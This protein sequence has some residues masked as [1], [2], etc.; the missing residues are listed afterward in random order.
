MMKLGPWL[1]GAAIG[2]VIGAVLVALKMGAF[3]PYSQDQPWALPTFNYQEIGRDSIFITGSLKGERVGYPYNTW[4]IRCFRSEE[5]CEVSNVSEIGKN[6]LGEID[7]VDWPIISWTDSVV[8]LQDDNSANDTACARATITI[9]R[10]GKSV[11]Y[12]SAS[13]NADKDYCKKFGH[14]GTY[15]WTI[16]QPKQP[17]EAGATR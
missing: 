7:T 2:G 16:G 8:V 10:E 9:N 4:N 3:S 11:D 14:S 17:W 1:G 13:I 12:T 5:R 6:Q 15:Q